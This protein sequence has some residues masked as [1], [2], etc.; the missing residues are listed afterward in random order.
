MRMILAWL[1]PAYQSHQELLAGGRR[2]MIPPTCQRERGRGHESTI[3]QP[4]RAS[5]YALCARA[6]RP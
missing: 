1:V 3:S 5:Y 4:K 2:V 6:V